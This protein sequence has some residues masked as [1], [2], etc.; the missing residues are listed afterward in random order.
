MSYCAICFFSI[1]RYFCQQFFLLSL[2]GW[3]KKLSGP[4]L[5]YSGSNV[6]SVQT[7]GAAH[8]PDV[9]AK[10]LTQHRC[11]LVHKKSRGCEREGHSADGAGNAANSAELEGGSCVCVRAA[12]VTES[13]TATTGRC[14]TFQEVM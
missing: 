12:L 5:A 1:E 8:Q 7:V 2:A 6:K 13:G 14:T 11:T 4:H 10:G 3:I 9:C